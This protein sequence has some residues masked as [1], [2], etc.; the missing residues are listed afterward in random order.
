MLKKIALLC[1]LYTIIY[2]T[3]RRGVALSPVADL[4]G[5]EHAAA[6]G[7]RCPLPVAGSALYCP[8]LHQ[9]LFNETVDILQE[10]KH[11]YRIRIPNLFFITEHSS[12]PHQ[13]YWIAKEHIVPLENILP[14][15]Q[16]AIPPPIEVHLE[17]TFDQK[18]I[19]LTKPWFSSM[20]G[21]TFSAGT[22][23][24]LCP[25]RV[26][27]S[28]RAFIINPGTKKLTVQAIPRT[29]AVLLQKR[30]PQEAREIFV[31]LLRSW[32]NEP[33]F[34]PYVW[35]G[36]SYT[37]RNRFSQE[38]TKYENKSGYFYRIK[39]DEAAQK[40]GFDCAGLIARAAQIAGLPYYYKNTTTLAAYLK[41]ITRAE[42]I[43]PGDLIWIPGH[44]IAITDPMKGLIVEARHYR[45]GYGKTYEAHISHSF[46]G[47]KSFADLVRALKTNKALTRLDI[48][49]KPVQTIYHYKILSL[50]S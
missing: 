33:G 22:R 41:P 20:L 44:V 4:F 17:D 43:R 14:D 50:E 21:L 37:Y 24:L 15:E 31:A 10:S 19:V 45:Y 38:N 7:K 35:G 40:C 27:N 49:G 30:T 47:I 8:R 23:F 9:L 46:K 1:F 16:N 12:K 18:I 26:S 2:T 39:G 29:D 48:S 11:A 32:A 6:S 28:F 25:T 3:P 34:I 13:I 5:S 36:C 42:D